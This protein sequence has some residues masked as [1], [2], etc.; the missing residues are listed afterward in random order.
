[1]KKQVVL[2]LIVMTL[3]IGFVGFAQAANITIVSPAKDEAINGTYTLNATTTE[4]CAWVSF[5]YSTDNATWTSIGTNNTNGTIFTFDWDTTK[6]SNG[7]YSLNAT[8][9]RTE[10]AYVNFSIDNV[11]ETAAVTDAPE[12]SIITMAALIGLLSV[13]AIQLRKKEK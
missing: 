4:N 8:S 13:A 3:L 12:F 6:V 5:N 10:S 2:A 11:V 7:N 1:M 9:N